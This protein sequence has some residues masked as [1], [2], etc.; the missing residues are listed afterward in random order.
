VNTGAA[1]TARLLGAGDDVSATQPAIAVAIRAVMATIHRWPGRRTRR[2]V[3][4]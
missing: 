1:L 2:C 4:A 3:I